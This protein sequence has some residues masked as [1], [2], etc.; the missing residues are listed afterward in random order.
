MNLKGPLPQ[1]IATQLQL[2]HPLLREIDS[3]FK[4]LATDLSIWSFFETVDSD[5]TNPDLI[6]TDRFPFHAPITSIKSALLN[7]RHE[8]VYPLLSDHAHCASFDSNNTQSKTSYLNDLA[9]AVKNSCELS[10]TKHTEM[11]LEDKVHVEVN[12]F[13]EDPILAN[14]AEQP[15]IRVWS[16]TRS[17]GAFKKF[18]PARLLKERLEEVNIAP[19]N[20]QYLRHGT[21]A[22][23]LR[24]DRP[25]NPRS[26]PSA[27]AFNTDL[28]D[29]KNPLSK[30][31]SGRHDKKVR[32]GQSKHKAGSSSS[33]HESSSRD[34]DGTV[35]PAVRDPTNPEQAM[36]SPADALGI[37][38]TAPPPQPVVLE[39]GR[40]DNLSTNGMSHLRRHSE[41][42]IQ[43]FLLRPDVIHRD[44]SPNR[45]RRGSESAINP[46]SQV[47][48]SKPDTS[49][50]KLVWVHVPYN[51]P[52]W[53]KV[54]RTHF[55]SPEK[56]LADPNRMFWKQYRLRR[57]RIITTNCLARNTGNPNMFVDGMLSTTH[58]LSSRDARSLDLK[59]VSDSS[60]P[61]TCRNL[62]TMH[63][64]SPS[65]SPRGSPKGKP[66]QMCLYLPY[67][68]F[69]T[70]KSLVKRRTLI[71][72]RIKQGRSRPVPQSVSK[73]ESLELRV[74]WQFLGHD[75]PINC[76]RTL[77]QFGY[78]GLLD[79]RARDDD[80]M[81]YKM[82][83]QLCSQPTDNLY[84]YDQAKINAENARGDHEKDH[85]AEDNEVSDESESESEDETDADILDGNVLMVDQVWLW[86]VDNGT[87]LISSRVE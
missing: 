22:P 23:S 19:R 20:T 74:L 24:P 1:T 84:D 42:P 55:L 77:D 73:M 71:M 38:N 41:A 32:K 63:I 25:K 11:K 47:T 60:W 76:R 30:P 17:L 44:S 69:D 37:S 75:P 15:A 29:T 34:P 4:A 5:L 61:F 65:A 7:L 56:L 26:S 83:K 67:L 59:S 78:P 40:S 13:Y 46:T 79:T 52:S 57:D 21:R 58:V 31:S 85:P 48:F 3:N 86:I 54:S 51:N 66:I 64:A 53:V 33:H 62:L 9:N 70:Y 82:T 10:Q 50:Q 14:D 36:P 39:P 8:V 35:L 27:P 6:E 16:T 72:R 80:Q 2:D 49:N 45:G 81:L 12:G 18:G 87:L 68:H 28:F 43:P